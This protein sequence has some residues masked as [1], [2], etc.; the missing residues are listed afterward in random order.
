[1]N[2]NEYTLSKRLLCIASMLED[3][4]LKYLIATEDSLMPSE[5][6]S[7]VYQAAAA[8]TELITFAITELRKRNATH[9]APTP[10]QLRRK[11]NTWLAQHREG[12]LLSRP[13][14]PTLAT[15]E[16][17]EIIT[18]SQKAMQHGMKIGRKWDAFA[19]LVK[20]E[21]GARA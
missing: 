21:R 6:H 19:G 14:V 8:W 2:N 11:A 3:N 13:L 1:M 12:V 15:S 5:Y 7:A 10:E 18:L 16:L 4:T 17:E 20:T 9:A